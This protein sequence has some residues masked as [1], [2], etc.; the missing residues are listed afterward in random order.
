LEE[1]TKIVCPVDLSHGTRNAVA[2]AARLAR[3]HDAE[4]H[5]LRV[6]RGESQ[7]RPSR[8]E[9][10]ESRR[11]GAVVAAALWGPEGADAYDEIPLHLA[12]ERGQPVRAIAAYARRNA[13]DLIV[14]GT[15]YGTAR[16]WRRSSS[17]ARALGRS[18][19]CPVL[20]VPQPDQALAV[21]SRIPFVDVVCAVDFA[22]ASVAALR[23]AIALAARGGGRLTLVHVVEGWPGRMVFSASEGLRKLDAYRDRVAAESERLRAL[24]PAHSLDPS[25][26]EAVVSSGA[27]HRAI[28]RTASEAKADLVVMGVSPRDVLGEVLTG[29]TSRAVFRRVTCPVLLV[30]TPGA[31]SA[32]ETAALPAA[33]RAAR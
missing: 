4:L 29:S 27:P 26:V 8:A 9:R 17:M 33:R 1:V 12:T 28:L 14:I 24:V 31:S 5:L 13:A 21:P 20:V 18:A 32:R 2:Y 23:A 15:R 25:R 3:I 11:L 30:P 16:S 6:P 10:A 22:P 7:E 19:E